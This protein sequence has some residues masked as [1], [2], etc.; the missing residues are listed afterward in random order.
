MS[1]LQEIFKWTTTLP[2]WQSDAV[3]RLLTKVDLDYSDDHDL[4]AMLYSENGIPDPEG[5][6][7]KPLSQDQVPAAAVPGDVV[8]LH[9]MEHLHHVN[10]IASDQS[11]MMAPSGV[12]VIYG[13]N[14]SGK[15]GYSRVLK[16]ACRARDQSEPIHPNANLPENQGGVAQA[17]FEISLNGANQEIIWRLD[18]A[19]PAVLSSIAVFD[20]RCA[21]AYL[22]Q[23]ND[24]SYVPYGLDVFGSLARLSQRLKLKVDQQILAGAV[25]L[26]AFAHLRGETAVGKQI[27]A[28]TAKSKPEAIESLATLSAAE[29]LRRA[30]LGTSLKENNPKEKAQALRIRARRWAALAAKVAEQEARLS[31]DALAVVRQAADEYRTAKAAAELAAQL[32]SEGE[33]LLPGTG[34]DVWRELYEAAKRFSMQV[35]PGKTI[36]DLTPEDACLLCQ[37][38]LQEGAARMHRFEA[39]VQAEAENIHAAKKA[40]LAVVYVPMTKHPIAFAL[41]EALLLA[42]R[43]EDEGI[44][45]DLP[46]HE[47]ALLDRQQSIRKAAESNDWS[48]VLSLAT[49]FSQ[50]LSLLSVQLD[51]S[52]KALEE[53]S[54]EAA[55]KAMQAELGE[56]DARAQLG[57]VKDAVLSAVAKLAH[58]AR[59]KAC[60]PALRTNG[61]STKASELAEKVVSQEL[62]DALNREFAALKVNALRVSTQSR[63]ERGKPLHRLRLELPQSRTPSEILSE[64]EQRAIAIASF[65]AE[66]SLNGQTSGIIFDDPVCSLD[67]RRRELVAKRLVQEAAKRQVIVFTHDIYFLK[68]LAD[69]GKRLGVSVETQSVSRQQQGFGVTSADLPFEGKTSS[70]RVGVV[71]NVQVLAAK[72]YSQNDQANYEMHT[73]RAYTL[74]RLAWERSVE[75]VLL[76]NVVIRFRKSVDTQRLSGVAVSDGDYARVNDGMTK[77]SNYAHD[78]PEIAGVALPDPDELLT[79]ILAFDSFIKEVNARSVATE[80]VR[81]KG[82]AAAVAVA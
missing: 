56:L 34:G 15:S 46:T 79:D 13:D 39:F 11:V 19:P 74:L 26:G 8:L 59:L 2:P 25:D 76:R 71:K 12:T 32:H 73:V 50:R 38:P 31:D 29:L 35:S 49:S 40:A 5:R 21:R 1:I 60:L 64:G 24:F 44:A 18:A 27:A 77:C 6:I 66:I 69:D 9:T 53:A 20:A 43:S 42:L 16:R 36:V 7:A 4:L 23:E 33:S 10:A 72:A 62:A 68:L 45:E 3:G 52:A 78:R 70:Q 55:R 54:D 28:L 81:K 75:E 58:L 14:G 57:L 61:I 17:T 41:D 67:H 30:E 48:V 47:T 51:L 37:Q 82:P 22:E 65:L 80:V 63:S